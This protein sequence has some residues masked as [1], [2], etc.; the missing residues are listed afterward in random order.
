MCGRGAYFSSWDFSCDRNY[1]SE[2]LVCDL[3]LRTVDG[4]SG[5]V[6]RRDANVLSGIVLDA[7]YSSV[8]LLFA[9][10]AHYW[11]K[12]PDWFSYF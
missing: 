1:L 2:L 4:G 3:A 11:L 6:C 8:L 7:H 5:A 12:V 10:V 9:E